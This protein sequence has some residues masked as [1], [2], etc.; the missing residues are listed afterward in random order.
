MFALAFIL[1]IQHDSPN[2]TA[3]LGSVV[4]SI[5]PQLL[6]AIKYL[7]DLDDSVLLLQFS[8]LRLNFPMESNS[9]SIALTETI[10]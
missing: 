10:S 2:W 9:Q 6:W 5:Q 8:V 7:M 1:V 3:W 4:A